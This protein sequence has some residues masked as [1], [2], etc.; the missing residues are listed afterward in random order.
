MILPITGVDVT[1]VANSEGVPTAMG[2][3]AP[4]FF[5]GNLSTIRPEEEDALKHRVVP[6]SSSKPTKKPREQ[7][8]LYD[9]RVARW[10]E[11]KRQA[12]VIARKGRVTFDS[13]KEELVNQWKKT[14]R[15]TD[16]YRDGKPTELKNRID[17]L[18]TMLP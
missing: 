16:L 5:G 3:A 2:L 8:D 1:E 6:L 14:G 10:S 7:Q 15:S 13:A 4:A 11:E 12:E 17:R 9:A 18:R